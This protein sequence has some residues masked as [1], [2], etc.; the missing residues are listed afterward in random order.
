MAD[1][2]GQLFERSGVVPQDRG[3]GLGHLVQ[4]A[5]IVGGGCFRHTRSVYCLKFCVMH[6]AAAGC[7]AILMGLFCT[8]E[9]S[10]GTTM[11]N[12]L[13]PTSAE[14]RNGLSCRIL[15]TKSRISRM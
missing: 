12:A 5:F 4:R 3:S 11:L 10:A 14:T 13:I 9:A 8:L 6:Q 1:G 7:A 2:I 15:C